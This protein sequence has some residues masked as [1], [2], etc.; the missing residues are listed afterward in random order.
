MQKLIAIAIFTAILGQPI[1]AS[2]STPAATRQHDVPV[3]VDYFTLR[4]L[5]IVTSVAG[6][7]LWVASVPIQ[8]ITRP[9]DMDKSFKSMVIN[10]IRFT[11]VDP[12]GYHPDRVAANSAGE[13]R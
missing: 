2:A 8:V 11:W 9:T 7:G 6:F 4:P 12:I 5:G 13:I 10:P 1:G 3:L